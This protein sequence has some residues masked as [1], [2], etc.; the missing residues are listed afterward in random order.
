MTL[1]LD[2]VRRVLSQVNLGGAFFTTVP[3]FAVS[4]DGT[5]VTV[6][7]RLPDR[8]LVPA[9]AISEEKDIWA[10][11]KATTGARLTGQQI[12]RELPTFESKRQLLSFACA[13]LVEMMVHETQESFLLQSSQVLL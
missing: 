13:L 4:T 5:E 7:L 12:T 8:D 3:I 2:D 6:S 10:F 1:L 11:V 9:P